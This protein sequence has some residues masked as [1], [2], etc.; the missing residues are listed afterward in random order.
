M[1]FYVMTAAV[2]AAMVMLLHG[3]LLPVTARRRMPSHV[4]R[5]C[6]F[7]NPL[8]HRTQ[9]LGLLLMLVPVLRLLRYRHVM[10]MMFRHATLAPTLRRMFNKG[11]SVVDF[12][13]REYWPLILPQNEGN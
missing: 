6:T 1:V 11:A 7:L 12:R 9:L 10:L 3:W 2:F 5:R 13:D 8:L 4:A